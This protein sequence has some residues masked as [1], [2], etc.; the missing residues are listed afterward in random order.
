MESF[1]ASAREYRNCQNKMFH[2]GKT[3]CAGSASISQLI[4]RDETGTAAAETPTRICS[5]CQH[6]LT[7]PKKKEQPRGLFCLLACVRPGSSAIDKF[8]QLSQAVSRAA[9]EFELF[10]RQTPRGRVQ[11]S[12]VACFRPAPFASSKRCTE[13]ELARVGQA[14][15]KETATI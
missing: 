12:C 6:R 10:V 11:H 9:P 15:G 3:S 4:E 7:M 8:E 14:A 1:Q 2:Q 5:R 13:R